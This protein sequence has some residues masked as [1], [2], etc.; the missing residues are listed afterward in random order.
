MEKQNTNKYFQKQEISK[1][2]GKLLHK[3]G[4]ITEK[5]VEEIL[6]YQRSNCHLRFGEIA[7]MWRITNQET[8][9]FFV[10]LFP[11][12]ITDSHKK[13]VGEYLKLAKL[14]NE[15][16]IYSILVEQSKTNLRFGEVAV[17]KGWLRQE[18]IDFVLQ[19][20]KG[21]FTPTVES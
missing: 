6:Q 17:Q 8:V 16:Q 7:V 13:T 3:A 4:L 2:I 21:E 11:L 9:D 14:L 18:T 1:P 10:D 15:K 20:I 19:Y 12:L 5:E